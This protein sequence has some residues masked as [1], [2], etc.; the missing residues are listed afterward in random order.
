MDPAAAPADAFARDPARSTDPG[1][2]PPGRGAGAAD[3]DGPA[4]AA[5]RLRAV[6]Q[7]LDALAPAALAQRRLPVISGELDALLRETQDAVARIVA[8][9]SEIL[10]ADPRAEGGA[11][12]VGARA[13]EILEACCFGDIAAQRLTRAAGNLEVVRNRVSRFAEVWGDPAG[14]DDTAAEIADRSAMLFGPGRD[15]ADQSR[16]DAV[17]RGA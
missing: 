17:F 13:I 11:D 10:A 9:A 14:P 1:G 2:D 15:P 5:D 6:A 4:A 8:A 7:A 3:P 12:Q 16:A